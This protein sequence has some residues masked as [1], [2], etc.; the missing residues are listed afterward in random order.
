MWRGAVEVIADVLLLSGIFGV[1][2]KGE[3]AIGYLIR[4]QVESSVAAG[5]ELDVRCRLHVVFSKAGV[6]PP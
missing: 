4:K 2:A 6:G 3:R 1:D 5:I